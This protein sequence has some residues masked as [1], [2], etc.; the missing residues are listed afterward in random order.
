MFGCNL[1]RTSLRLLPKVEVKAERVKEGPR[2]RAKLRSPK[3]KPKTDAPWLHVS[4]VYQFTANGPEITVKSS[5]NRMAG[6]DFGAMPLP[7]TQ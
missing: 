4:D 6:L 2:A 1:G 5:T 7:S 3:Q